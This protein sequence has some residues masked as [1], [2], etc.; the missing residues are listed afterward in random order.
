M[1]K[2]HFVKFRFFAFNFHYP[3]NKHPTLET[4][5]VIRLMT[6]L[7]CNNFSILSATFFLY[8]TFLFS[9]LFLFGK[10][11]QKL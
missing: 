7:G 4:S 5:F 3:A 8:T 11:L 1:R 6:L 10:V 9:F 2:F